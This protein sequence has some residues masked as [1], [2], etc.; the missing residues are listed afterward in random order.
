M[1]RVSRSSD[2]SISSHLS[3]KGALRKSGLG[4]AAADQKGEGFGISAHEIAEQ[5][6][7]V[8]GIASGEDFV[9]EV[10]A[11]LRVENAFLLESSE[12]VG[13]KH[14]GPFVAVITCSVT[15][16]IAEQVTEAAEERWRLG[17]QGHEV[18]G[19]KAAGQ[20]VEILVGLGR[21]I[22][23]EFEVELAEGELAHHGAGGAEVPGGDEFFEQTTWNRI[24]GFEMAGEEVQAF[25]FPAEVLHD[26]GGKFDEVPIDADA[27]ERWDFDVAAEL[28]EQVA[29]FMKHGADFIMGEEGG[30][31]IER[32]SHVA[33]DEAE[34]EAAIL[35]I[36]RGKAHFEIVHPGTAAF[37][38]AR[39]PVGVEG[40]DVG[41]FFVPDFVKFDG[42]VPDL[43]GAFVIWASADSGR[44]IGLRG[45]E[46]G[47]TG[48]DGK[49]EDALGEVE[50]AGEDLIKR[51]PGAEFFGVE[52][53]FGAAL[54]F[55]PEGHLPGFEEVW[56]AVLGI[57]A[58]LLKLNG[59][60]FE[61]WA[62]ALVEVVDEFQSGAAGARHALLEDLICE[63][64]LAE[65]AGFFVSESKDLPDERGI[66]VGFAVADAGGGLPDLLADVFVFEVFENGDERG[67]FE[68]E[69]EMGGFWCAEVFGLCLLA[70]GIDCAL[71]EALEARG[72]VDDQVPGVGGIEDVLGVLLSD[73]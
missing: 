36:G 21:R 40:A 19:E 66:V 29:E 68:G 65:E 47:I 39:V 46:N 54:F 10:A 1:E 57:G 38:V 17:L 34:V 31:A 41:A 12:G 13:I 37:G 35:A 18:A 69:A 24:A 73:F 6:G 26:L 64:L 9:P 20:G 56:S 63:M 45:D 3:Q 28:M 55:G 67:G 59:F 43:D 15:D 61:G 51:E 32:R 72:V 5:L 22:H 8:F 25:A 58:E 52:V 27:V 33:A 53:V 42:G 71:G 7:G 2:V 14:F 49:I 4:E 30:F 70:G 48:G 62:D 60:F 23:V 50:H 11:D 44:G 16:G